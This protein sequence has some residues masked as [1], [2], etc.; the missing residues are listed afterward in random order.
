MVKSVG[1]AKSLANLWRSKRITKKSHA[2]RGQEIKWEI[3]NKTGDSHN[4]LIFNMFQCGG[5]GAS[6]NH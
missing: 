2:G 6:S 4:Q 3:P 1:I 5:S